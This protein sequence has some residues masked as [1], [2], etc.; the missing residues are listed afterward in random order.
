MAKLIMRLIC[1]FALLAL[2]GLTG[3]A[4]A[5]APADNQPVAPRSVAGAQFAERMIVCGPRRG[6]RALREGCR[7]VLAPHPRNNR[8]RCTP[9]G[10]A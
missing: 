8:V 2:V 9:V 4:T 5:A 7:L 3:A 6:C 10:A 1:S